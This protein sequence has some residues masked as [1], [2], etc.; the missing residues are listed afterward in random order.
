VSLKASGVDELCEDK[1]FKGGAMDVAESFETAAL[2]HKRFAIS[3][4]IS[5]NFSAIPLNTWIIVI[6]YGVVGTASG[7]LLWYQGLA[8]I[9][10]STA[11]VFTGIVPISA[12]VLSYIVLG[13]PF[14]WVHVIGGVCVV[15]AIFIMDR[16]NAR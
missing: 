9:S 15:L 4:A 13:E 11:G 7:Y 2:L 10:A 6:Y 1:L 3:Q 16:S 12:V 5:F 14:S 8:H